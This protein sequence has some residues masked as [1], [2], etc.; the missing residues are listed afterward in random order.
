MLTHPKW[1]P[2]KVPR[3]HLFLC[4]YYKVHPSV[5][6]SHSR[7]QN[8]HGAHHFACRLSQIL[9]GVNWFGS[10]GRVGWKVWKQD[11][12]CLD[13]LVGWLEKKYSSKSGG[14]SWWWIP[15]WKVKNHQRNKS[16]FASTSWVPQEST[17][18]RPK[19]RGGEL[20]SSRG[21]FRSPVPTSHLRSKGCLVTAVFPLFISS[22][23]RIRRGPPVRRGP[24]NLYFAG[25]FLGPQNDTTFEGSGFLGQELLPPQIFSQ[26]HA[27]CTINQM[28]VEASVFCQHIMDV[29]LMMSFIMRIK[30]AHPPNV[31]PPWNKALTRPKNWDNGKEESLSLGLHFFGKLGFGR[32]PAP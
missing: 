26:N 11:S 25:V 19:K 7:H 5:G 4:P 18:T 9:M 2:K 10:G 29:C 15:W 21:S 6:F 30:G 23:L 1:T 16:K 3:L 24:I 8:H 32:G 31:K 13:M 20:C 17:R 14:F 28:L 27:C 22:T 12:V